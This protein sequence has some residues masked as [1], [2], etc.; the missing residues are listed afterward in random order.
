MATVEDAADR[1]TSIEEQVYNLLKGINKTVDGASGETDEQVLSLLTANAKLKYRILHIERSIAEQESKRDTQMTSV[2]SIVNALF[3]SAVRHAY[4]TF[5]LTK[6][7]VQSSSSERFGDYK[8]TVAMPIAQLLKQSGETSTPRDI[9]SKI[10]VHLPSSD[11]IDKCE[12]A[13]PGFINIFL[14]K[15]FVSHMVS[16]ILT[17]GVRPPPTERKLR[18][19][20]DFSSPNIAK[21][22][23]V[24]HLRSTIIGET[25]CR[26]LEYIG[27]DV[28]RLN[29]IGDWGTQFGMLIAHL[30]EQF[31][32]Y[33]QEA[34]PIGDLQRFYQESKKR[35]DD[36]EEFK[37]RSY[38]DVVK[39]QN[40]DVDV[41]KA[42][43]LIC[44]VSREEMAD[45]YKRLDV[46]II[47]RGESFYQPMMS[48]TVKDLET[49]NL[50]VEEDGRKLVFVPG[51]EVPLTIVKSDGGFT[52]D[53]SDMTALYHRIKEEK[54]DWL[55]YVVDS[56]QGPHFQSIFGAAAMA[57]YVPD[58]VRIDHVGF[59]VV[60]GED[61]KKFKT[62]S[63][64]SVR[65]KDLLDEGLERSLARLQE[66]ERDKVLSPEELIA[67]QKSVAY[68]CIKY[69]D[70]C[71]TR[72][73]DYVFSFDKMLDDRGNTAVY[74]LYAYTRLRSIIRL[75]G[76]TEQQLKDASSI[77]TINVE[78]EKEFKLA[79]C[80][81]RFP[82]V[83]V[84]V[85]DDLYPH[86]LCDY[87]YELCTIMT[88]FYDV[89][90]CVEKDRETGEVISVDTNRILLCEATRKILH[91]A[92][93]IMGINPV[94]RM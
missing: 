14:K 74:L 34:P 32:N 93:Y 67:A 89:C 87:L 33:I 70:L 17:Y 94:E 20:V 63:G 83:I 73:N 48:N 41:R 44:D 78:H 11:A 62:R 86:T 1:I 61:K 65:L 57:G 5:S 40:G 90:Y 54:A 80:I 52:Y 6:P 38:S 71:H 58:H 7:I 56:G 26:L 46:T 55:I 77:T 3:R 29:H 28:L 25:I 18:V 53:T 76:V 79:K 39:L 13:G 45:V 47:E 91:E 27:H 4:P 88:E 22:M 92:F 30:K 64:D 9:A 59:G 12:V 16:E 85:A 35:F 50:V 21:E 43:N 60:L 72:T 68:G 19:V 84:R 42:W 66:K 15:S 8:C 31:P 10:I 36:D 2:L 37:K 75:S 51:Q 69:A 82:E 23:H 49:K 81:I 24:G